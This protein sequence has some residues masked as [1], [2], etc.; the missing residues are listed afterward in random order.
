MRRLT[1]PMSVDS[2]CY[3]LEDMDTTKRRDELLGYAKNRLI[4][5]CNGNAGIPWTY[6]TVQ[7]V[8]NDLEWIVPQMQAFAQTLG[9][10]YVGHEDNHEDQDWPPIVWLRFEPDAEKLTP[11]LR[12]AQ[13]CAH[14]DKR[15]EWQQELIRTGRFY[16]RAKPTLYVDNRDAEWMVPRLEAHMKT[17]GYVVCEKIQQSAAVNVIFDL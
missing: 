14:L 10:K 17:R 7:S 9:W 6:A 13:A 3:A 1:I 11:D 15:I 5:Q 2:L 4:V 8:P 12:V 16:R